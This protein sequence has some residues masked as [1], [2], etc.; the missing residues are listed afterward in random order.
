[1]TQTST[2]QNGL[3]GFIAAA[4][5]ILAISYP[6]LAISTGFR[7][8][9]QLLVER[10]IEN[11]TASGLSLVA[12]LCYLVATIGFAKRAKWAWKVSVAVLAFETAMTFLIGGLSYYEP[13]VE[14]IGRTVWRY[15]GADYGYLPLIQP[16]LGIMW[17]FHPET[18]AG[19][20]VGK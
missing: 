12:A 11:A 2:S 19:Y 10:P 5:V 14:V 4:G 17:L 13:A 7:A 9:Y 6:V 16:L 18:R 15:F 8:G 20:N 1:M 3:S